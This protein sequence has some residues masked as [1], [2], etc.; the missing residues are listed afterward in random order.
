MV[1]HREI[2][3]D[4]FGYATARIAGEDTV[5][6][7]DPGRYGVLSGE[8]ADRYGGADYPSGGP[9]EATDGD[10]VLVTHDH[11]YDDAVERVANDDATVVV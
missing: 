3:L 5:A 7:T 9:Y 1:R 2:S 6:Y 10:V 11:H 8:W 4:W